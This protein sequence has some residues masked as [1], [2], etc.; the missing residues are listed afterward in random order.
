MKIHKSFSENV[1]RADAQNAAELIKPVPATQKEAPEIQTPDI[2][3]ITD[4]VEISTEAKRKTNNFQEKLEKMRDDMR[5][6]REELKRAREAGE[7]AAEAWKEKI[8]CLQIAMRIISGDNVPYEDHR[9]LREK[10]VE[11][12]GR[13][14]TMR[15]EKEDPKDLDRL[16]EDEE[17]DG[18]EGEIN[19]ADSTPIASPDSTDTQSGETEAPPA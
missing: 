9:Y 1:Q 16:S 13:A 11:L 15:V 18:E 10:D 19:S 17:E 5:M 4:T 8:R 7:G 12:Y 3:H 2:A 14:I 6:L